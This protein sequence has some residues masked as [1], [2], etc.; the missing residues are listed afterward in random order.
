VMQCG[1]NEKFRSLFS[2]ITESKGLG[3]YHK[4]RCNGNGTFTW[5]CRWLGSK[6]SMIST[7]V[8]Q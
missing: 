8:V 3:L 6:V 7:T 2:V 1:L 4:Y 5:V